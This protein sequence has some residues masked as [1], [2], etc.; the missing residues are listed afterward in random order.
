VVS[1]KGIKV[2][3]AKVEAIVKW[4]QPENITEV[5]SLLGMAGY[6]QR[7]IKGFSSHL[8]PMTKLLHKN[9]PFVWNVKREQSFQELK[10]R[11]LLHRC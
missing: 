8:M 5:R 7:F 2:D 4:K 11:L 10:K 3:A 9:V 6:Y 1:K